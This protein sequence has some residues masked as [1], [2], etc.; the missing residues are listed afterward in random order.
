MQQ[1]ERLERV[2]NVDNDEIFLKLSHVCLYLFLND[3]LFPKFQEYNKFHIYDNV[4]STKI[5]SYVDFCAPV[6]F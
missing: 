3:I 6:K 4:S 2:L 5:F 1:N